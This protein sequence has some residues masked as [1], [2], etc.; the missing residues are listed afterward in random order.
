V[1]AELWAAFEL[2][3]P[4]QAAALAG[5]LGQM[6]SGLDAAAS[7][8]GT[9]EVSWTGAAATAF[10]ALFTAQ[11]RQFAAVAEACHTVAQAL[12]RH[13]ESL[14]TAHALQRRAAALHATD[15]AAATSLI[16]QAWAAATSSAQ[17]TARTVRAAADAAPERPG[18]LTRV[19]TRAVELMGEVRLG[20]AEAVEGAA[21]MA[22][23]LNQFRFVHAF[24]EAKADADIM[25]T[26]TADAARHPAV[27]LHAVT[28]WDTWTSN[29]ARAVGHLLPDAVAA[30]TTAGAATTMRGAALEAR[31]RKAIDAARAA[32]TRRREIMEI[33]GTAARRNLVEDAV[34]RG[35]QRF[36]APEPW[37]GVG[38][39]RLSPEDAGAV[40]T[41]WFMIA[42]REAGIT[43]MI[44]DLAQESQGV[45]MGIENRLKSGDSFR[46]KIATQQA[47]SGKPVGD[48]LARVNDAVRY[49]VVFAETRYTRGVI[50][51]SALLDR[52]GFHRV[53]VDNHWHRSTRY[54]GIN[55]TWIHAR[56]G[57]VVEVQFHTPGSNLAS[58]LTHGAYE[59][60]R[61]P[62]ITG[63]ER[64]QLNQQIADVYARAP[65]PP[66]VE[67]LSRHSIPPPSPPKAVVPPPDLAAAAGAGGAAASAGV[68]AI[69]RMHDDPA[70][71]AR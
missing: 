30:V 60:M 9:G 59:R 10:A 15:P 56:S 61:R 47:A 68:L 4:E 66:G 63:A 40:Q 21:R 43:R 36:R 20:A 37:T 38:G 65:Q 6:A 16:D 49:R 1:T 24:G 55:S 25:A 19:V 23:S 34:T 52:N 69:D 2:G 8:I 71:G 7:G 28:D 3:D 67:T 42:G 58:V 31:G 51:A 27:L 45:L 39:T 14:S 57:T 62:D 32:D 18:L 12:A 44:S 11:P 22:L 50:E 41:Y 46:R 5:H 33:A 26:G 54:R 64:R 17:A 29:P 53:D 70:R 48:L 35:S 13:A